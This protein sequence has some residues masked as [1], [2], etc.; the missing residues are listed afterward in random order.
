[1]GKIETPIQ[2]RISLKISE[3]PHNLVIRRNVGIFFTEYGGRITIGVTGEADLQ[4][5]IGN[6]RCPHCNNKIHPKPFACE[7]KAPGKPQS[8]AQ[9]KWQNQTWERRGALYV[10]A[11]SPEEAHEKL[12]TTQIYE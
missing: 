6:Q 11:T 12:N 7:V 5:F 4:G 2:D 8:E 3:S 10:L 9:I 1:M